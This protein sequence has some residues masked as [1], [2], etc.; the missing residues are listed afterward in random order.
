[1]GCFDDKHDLGTKA[2]TGIVFIAS[3]NLR[4]D[5]RELSIQTVAA[6]E[7]YHAGLKVIKDTTDKEAANG[8]YGGDANRQIAMAA[9]SNVVHAILGGED[10]VKTTKEMFH[11]LFR[12][13]DT[14][15]YNAGSANEFLA[16]VNSGQQ[17][18]YAGHLIRSGMD[19]NEANFIAHQ[20]DTDPTFQYVNSV[21]DQAAQYILLESPQ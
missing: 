9:A 2:P 13:V 11:G 15:F 8:G 19:E 3:N 21:I 5:V 18:L 6:H 10:E 20:A 16:Y 12:N 7:Y 1:L 17:D 4:S 14:F